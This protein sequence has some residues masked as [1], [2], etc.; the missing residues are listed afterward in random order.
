MSGK[1]LA[2]R[3]GLV[4]AIT[5]GFFVFL[6]VEANATPIRPDLQK[7]LAEP[8]EPSFAP[9]RAGWDGP[10]MSVTASPAARELLEHSAA[11]QMMRASLL[12]LLVPDFRILL[13]IGLAIILLR[14]LWRSARPARVCSFPASEESPPAKAA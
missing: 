5:A 10:E 4:L 11:R 14:R 2:I 12:A 1:G 7:L 8:Q 9:A 13:L 3:I 6:S